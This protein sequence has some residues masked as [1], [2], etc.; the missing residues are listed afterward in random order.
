MKPD[1]A[2]RLKHDAIA[3]Y[4]DNGEAV[5]VFFFQRC[6]CLHLSLSDGDEESG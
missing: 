5:D 4:S 2:M 1:G 6:R 3:E